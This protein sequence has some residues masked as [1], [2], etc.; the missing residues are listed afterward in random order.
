[1]DLVGVTPAHNP[2]TV[3]FIGSI[4]WRETAP[5]DARDLAAL[6]TGRRHVPGADAATLVAVARTACTSKPD[7]FYSAA[8]LLRA[9]P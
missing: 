9:W 6:A 5:F 1:V 4:K 2:T 7:A 3:P 8:H